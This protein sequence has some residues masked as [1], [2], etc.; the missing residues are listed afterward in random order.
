MSIL[1][2]IMYKTKVHGYKIRCWREQPDDELTIDNMNEIEAILE[3][4]N[5]DYFGKDIALKLLELPNMNAVEVLDAYDNG[6][7]VYK[8]W[9]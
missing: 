3:T 4:I 6:I 2:E 7:V 1:T 5:P 9:P 8:D